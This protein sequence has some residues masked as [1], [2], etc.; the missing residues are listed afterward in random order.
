MN[1][2]MLAKKILRIRYYWNTMEIN[3]VDF[4]KSCHDCQTHANLNHVPLS[5]LYSM[6]SHWPFSIWGID[7]IGRIAHKALNGHEYILMAN[8]YFIKWVEAASYSILKAKHVSRLI[9]NNIIC[10]YGVPQKII[11]DNGSHFE[12]EVRT[13]MEL[14]DIEHYK[15]SPYRPQTNGV[16][17]AANKNIKNILTKMVVTYKYWARKLP[18]AL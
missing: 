15:S 18:F 17:E 2:R 9:K 7:M 8:N 1:G 4:V 3:C 12:G 16:I 13:I 10:W 5:E 6:T 14:Y 11:S